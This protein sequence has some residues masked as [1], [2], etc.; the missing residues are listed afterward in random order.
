MYQDI[1]DYRCY[2]FAN[3]KDLYKVTAIHQGLQNCYRVI[4]TR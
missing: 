4:A 2:L 1:K 3:C